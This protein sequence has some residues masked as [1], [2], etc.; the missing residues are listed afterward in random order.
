MT[1]VITIQ[2]PDPTENLLAG[3]FKELTDTGYLQVYLQRLF[4][5]AF[6]K[7]TENYWNSIAANK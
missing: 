1:D 5:A 2:E 4:D 3:V 6:W 7:S